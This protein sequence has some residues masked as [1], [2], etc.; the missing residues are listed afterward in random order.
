MDLLMCEEDGDELVD[1]GNPQDDSGAGVGQDDVDE[2]G[3]LADEAVLLG[4]RDVLEGLVKTAKGLAG[5]DGGGRGGAGVV[6]G[7]RGPE[8]LE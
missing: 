4:L 2:A 7:S 1:V 5:D 6:G 3:Q 8:G